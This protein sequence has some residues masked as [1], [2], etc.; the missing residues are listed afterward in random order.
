M[1]I[2]INIMIIMIYDMSFIIV[3]HWDM[4]LAPFNLTTAM[5][6]THNNYSDYPMFYWSTSSEDTGNYDDNNK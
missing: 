1:I 4:R 5:N 2:M 3:K 6:I